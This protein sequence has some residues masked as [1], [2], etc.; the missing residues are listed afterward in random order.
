MKKQILLRKNQVAANNILWHKNQVPANNIL[1]H[2]N[3]V[4]ANNILWH[5]NKVQV[6]SMV[7]LQTLQ[8]TSQNQLMSQNQQIRK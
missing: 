2:K 7:P 4:A 6:S 1:W 8:T 5:K 3:Q